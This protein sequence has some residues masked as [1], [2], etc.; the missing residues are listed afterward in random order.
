MR[1]HAESLR[2]TSAEALERVNQNA[3]NL[4]NARLAAEGE[5]KVDVDDTR[6]QRIQHNVKPKDEL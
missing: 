5:G 2:A 1:I 3:V 6:S 4:M